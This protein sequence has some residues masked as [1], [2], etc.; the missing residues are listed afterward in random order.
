MRV[1]ATAGQALPT[2]VRLTPP[3]DEVLLC[4]DNGGRQ[5]EQMDG[6]VAR[7][8]WQS[9]CVA[10]CPIGG[11]REED[12]QVQCAERLESFANRSDVR[13]KA[14]MPTTDVSTV[15]HRVGSKV[16]NHDRKIAR[17]VIGPH[18]PE[19][20]YVHLHEEAETEHGHGVVRI[21]LDEHNRRERCG[22]PCIL[23]RGLSR[24]RVPTATR[25]PVVDLGPMHVT[26]PERRAAVIVRPR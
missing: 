2:V 12:G 17:P 14:W 15:P 13:A 10:R 26:R 8:V 9:C 22:S 5:R 18:A 23:R 7:R 3:P 16:R 21:V 25:W 24:G 20:P 4:D 11:P 19:A 6:T 1:G